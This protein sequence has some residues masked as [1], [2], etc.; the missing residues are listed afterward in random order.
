MH[1]HVS[2]IFVFP[3]LLPTFQ[4]HF[5]HLC[6]KWNEQV[7]MGK[8]GPVQVDVTSHLANAVSPQNFANVKECIIQF[9]CLV[10]LYL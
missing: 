5:D 9:A 8:E 1:V 3:G 2:M 4:R 7:K 6:K 10:Y